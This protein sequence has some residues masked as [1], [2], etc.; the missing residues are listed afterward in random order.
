MILKVAVVVDPLSMIPVP[1][2]LFQTMQL[3][4][5]GSHTPVPILEVEIA[6]D[7]LPANVQLKNRGLALPPSLTK[8]C[9]APLL[10]EKL[11]LNRQLA[12][13]GEHSPLLTAIF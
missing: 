9:T 5:V 12:K 1:P 6:V 10:G 2:P 7:E 13:I 8:E 3:V 11:P 4:R